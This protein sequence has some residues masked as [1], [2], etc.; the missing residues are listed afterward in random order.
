MVAVVVDVDGE[1]ERAINDRMIDD[2][3]L[4]LEQTGRLGQQRRK[5]VYF[6]QAELSARS[7]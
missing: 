5:S 6:L 3:L 4:D 1:V 2:G 7:P